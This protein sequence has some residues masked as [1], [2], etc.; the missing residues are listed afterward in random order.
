MSH[1]I[2][3][4]K[5]RCGYTSKKAV[6]AGQFPF[7]AWTFSSVLGRGRPPKAKPMCSYASRWM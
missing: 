4:V 5:Q 2:E 6:L 3:Q 7:L 1:K